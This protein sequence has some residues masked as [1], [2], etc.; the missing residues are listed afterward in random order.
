MVTYEKRDDMSSTTVFLLKALVPMLV[1]ALLV[2]AAVSSQADKTADE[3]TA[4][5]AELALTHSQ[6][7]SQQQISRERKQLIDFL[8]DGMREQKSRADVFFGALETCHKHV[9]SP[10][11][12]NR[13]M[14]LPGS[15]Q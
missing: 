9:Y 13:P 15:E 4:L 5:R 2:S 8:S 6:L 1:T 7:Q 10:E 11:K 14:P 3:L 12:F